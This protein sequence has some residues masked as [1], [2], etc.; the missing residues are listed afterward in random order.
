[1]VIPQFEY[2]RA[3][4]SAELYFR[5]C[6]VEFRRQREEVLRLPVWRW[7]ESQDS[8]T[9]AR[10]ATASQGGTDP[11]A[12][13]YSEQRNCLHMQNLVGLLVERPDS[14]A[15]FNRNARWP[16]ECT[17]VDER[18]ARYLAMH[19]RAFRPIRLYRDIAVAFKTYFYSEKRHGNT[20][21]EEIGS[22][23]IAIR[24]A[25]NTLVKEAG[26][27]CHSMPHPS[28][29]ATRFD[30]AI[31]KLEKLAS[32]LRRDQKRAYPTTRDDDTAGERR[33]VWDLWNA[34]H[35]QFGK[36]KATAISYLVQLEGVRRPPE[37]RAIERAIT[38]WKSGRESEPR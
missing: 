3:M 18:F 22:A 30:G 38:E 11:M 15:K 20:H 26:E 33:L 16:E 13:G 8:F 4:E 35:Q 24:K 23:V 32:E 17:A 31:R 6:L 10:R 19:G 5:S 9:R 1:L 29:T 7:M 34:F 14:P 37:K 25:I 12:E 28:A 21:S 2:G 27:V 36:N